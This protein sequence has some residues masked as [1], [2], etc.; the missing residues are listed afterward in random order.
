MREKGMTMRRLAWGLM[1]MVVGAV[2]SCSNATCTQQYP[3]QQKEKCT[4]GKRRA[5]H[6]M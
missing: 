6:T 2:R 4:R 5:E 1:T 3:P